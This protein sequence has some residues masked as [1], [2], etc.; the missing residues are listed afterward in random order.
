MTNFKRNLIVIS[1]LL[2][3]IAGAAFAQSLDN[4]GNDFYMAFMPNFDSNVNIQVH[5]TSETTTDVT[6]QYPANSPTFNQTVTVN[7]GAITIVSLPITPSAGWTP[8]VVQDNLVRAFGADEFVAY[9][10]NIRPFS[11][12]AA[13]ALPVDTYNTEFLVMSYFSTTVSTDRSEFAVVSAFDNTNVT[14]TPKAPL[15][16][17][18][19]ANVP[20]TI[21]LNQGEGFLAQ[22]TTFGSAG[23][24]TG[25][26][27]ESDKPIS[28]TNGNICTNV[29]PN[30]TFCDH[31]FEV[32]Q[33]T[34]TWGNRSL[35]QNLTN[36]PQGAVYRVLAS[37]DNT[38]LELD[39]SV[40]ATLNKGE[41]F[42]TN[43][44]PGSHEF[45][46]DK[47]I[48]VTQFMT[49]VN[50]GSGDPAMGNQI[51]PDQYQNAYTFSTVGGNQFIQHF[52]N[53]IAENGDVGSILLDGSPL[54][55]GLFSPIG[56]SGYSAATV[57]ISDGTHSTSSPNGHGI[58]VYGV[59][60]DDSYIYP[61]GALF[62]FINPVGDANP[63]I[64]DININGD[65]ANGSA[66][67]NR[68][69]EDT[70]GNGDLDSSEDLNNNGQIDEDTGIFFLVL[71]AGSNNVTLNV[72]PFVPGDGVVNYSVS[73]IDNSLPASG[74]I[75]AT[76]GAGNTCTS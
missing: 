70:N 54:A 24:L 5:L 17:G 73:V 49:G 30:Q 36:N 39:G 32:A 76:D 53:I 71:D 38:S 2:F 22:G 19:P 16:G 41:F 64:C 7:P 3:G 68:P 8:G 67:D 58:T 40:V 25:S 72:D 51:P 13:L 12:D 37:Q 55:G 63:P 31:I 74:V 27:V 44:L 4:K 59:N 26:L 65:Q 46:A 11:S 48:F 34:Q 15:A 1:M 56:S 42:E 10:I 75:R 14:I 6:V 50:P 23:D 28:M 57:Q 69:S 60:N 47:P 9:M 62:N 66:I 18:F 29:P 52:V 35:V 61:G 33:P 45:L 43:R 20:F 21:T